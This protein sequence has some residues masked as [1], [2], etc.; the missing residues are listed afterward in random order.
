MPTGG[1]AAIIGIPARNTRT[2]R[3]RNGSGSSSES[4]NGGKRKSVHKPTRAASPRRMAIRCGP[5]WPRGTN[6]AMSVA[7]IA[8]GSGQSPGTSRRRPVDHRVARHVRRAR[9]SI[10]EA[11]GAGAIIARFVTGTPVLSTNP[12]TGAVAHSNEAGR[13]TEESVAAARIT[14]RHANRLITVDA[15]S[16]ARSG[17]VP[18]K[19]ARR[20]RMAARATAV[21]A[22]AGRMKSDS[23]RRP[24][25]ASTRSHTRAA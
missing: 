1:P 8:R 21:H 16:Q 13:M 14:I 17:V 7:A 2:P 15:G 11:I 25:P 6:R 23:T 4:G 10:R 18:G 24:V 20:S 19:P 5:R 9:A 3:R 22:N 12:R